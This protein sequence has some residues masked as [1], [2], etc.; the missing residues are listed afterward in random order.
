MSVSEPYLAS[1]SHERYRDS[2]KAARNTT[3]PFHTVA[4]PFEPSSVFPLFLP[5]GGSLRYLRGVRFPI[6]YFI[7]KLL[8]AIVWWQ[9]EQ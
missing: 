3:H 4:V 8:P 2:S 5:L 9:T 1:N 6:T 7:T